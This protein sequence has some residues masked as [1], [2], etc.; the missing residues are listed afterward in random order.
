MTGKLMAGAIVLC[1]L[2]AGIGVYYFQVY[3]FYEEVEAQGTNDVELTVMASGTPE[4][5]LY[6]SFEA[7]DADSSPIRYRACFTTT[8]SFPMLT[9]T[10]EP[11]EGAE[12][13][14]APGW[15]DCFDAEAIGAEIDAG[16]A[17]VFTGER[18]IEFGI[19]RVVAITDDG[20][21][22]VWHEINECG[23]KAYDGTPLGED[24]PE[25]PQ[26]D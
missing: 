16:T 26:P 1:G 25:R 4:P 15:F 17:L 6:D 2:L 12:P 11:Y 14:T 19:D 21:G 24:C 23:D 5:I 10:Y 18:N 22:Y 7:I 3:H 9:E 20:R 13:R 8:M